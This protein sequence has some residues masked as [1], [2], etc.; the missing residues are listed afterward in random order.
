MNCEQPPASLA[1][2]SL[3]PQPHVCAFFNSRDD[4]YR[5]LLP[6]VKEGLDRREKAIHIVDPVLRDEHLAR[7]G[8]AGIAVDPAL[9]SRQLEVLDWNETYL[10]GGCFDRRG[11]TARVEDMLSRARTEGFPRVRIVGHMDWAL[12][13]GCDIG[14]LVE[15]EARMNDVLPPHHDPALCAYDR[16]R[17]PA[18]VAMDILRAHPVVV[19]EGV[20][21][22]NPV[23]LPAARLLPR[24]KRDALTLLRDRYLTALVVG[25]RQ[26]ALEVG[27]EEALAE[28]VP[29]ASVYL[30]VIQAAQYEVG[31]LW[32][33]RR[34]SVAQ[35][36]LATEISRSVMGQL[37]PHLP[38]RRT[39]GKRAVVACVEGELHDLGARMVADFL[40]MAGFEVAYLGANVPDEHLA[41]LVRERRPDLVAL[42]ATTTSHAP[43]LRRAIGVVRAVEGSRIPIAAGGQ[44]LVRKPDL[45]RR[46][47]IDIQARD[48]GTLIAVLE[49]V[50]GEGSTLQ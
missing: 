34:L 47:G 42:S 28:D 19:M 6:F 10:R 7:M 24:L 23:F 48:A 13:D 31:R 3:G 32:Q 50:L 20:L 14:A 35:E 37:Q 2:G 27:V 30:E 49:Q 39:N 33:A 18:N 38:F 8:G 21:Q 36:H 11:M 4:E 1:G 25:A 12:Q 43:A 40:E 15:Y 46:L 5:T 44:L 26:E 22:D 41:Q 29:A 45:G 17:F 16:S 9:A